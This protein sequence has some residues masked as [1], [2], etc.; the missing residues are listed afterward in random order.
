MLKDFGP[1]LSKCVINTSL[2]NTFV[3][4]GIKNTRD[5]VD[6]SKGRPKFEALVPV[7]NGG[8][9]ADGVSISGFVLLDQ[10]SNN[11]FAML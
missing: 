10:F 11:R 8:S 2:S 7:P 1:V 5:D 9:G 4:I 3:A 6:F